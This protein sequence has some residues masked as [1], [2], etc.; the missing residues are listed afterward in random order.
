MILG[1]ITL[2]IICL[3]GG[4]FQYYI[5]LFLENFISLYIQ[6]YILIIF[7]I[8]I[9]FDN[10]QLYN[11]LKTIEKNIRIIGDKAI[12]IDNNK[13]NIYKLNETI[14]VKKNILQRLNSF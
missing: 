4:I 6:N 12:E 5:S 2:F 3:I 13:I 9:Q 11:E 7:S 10:L 1:L 14:K 8:L